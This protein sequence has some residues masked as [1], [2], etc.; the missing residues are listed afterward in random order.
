MWRQPS[1]ECPL[2]FFQP[3]NTFNKP[4]NL[5]WMLAKIRNKTTAAQHEVERMGYVTAKTNN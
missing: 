5:N 1:A 4:F 3:F 2:D